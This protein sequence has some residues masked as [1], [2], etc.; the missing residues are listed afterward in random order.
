MVKKWFFSTKYLLQQSK[1]SIFIIAGFF[2][3]LFK[4]PLKDSE[5]K[6]KEKDTKKDRGPSQGKCCLYLKNCD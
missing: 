1:T 3:G 6:P 4:K 5:E 2:G